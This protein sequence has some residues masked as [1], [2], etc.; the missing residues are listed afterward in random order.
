V[1]SGGDRRNGHGRRFGGC[2]QLNLSEH[3]IVLK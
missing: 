1:I 3:K 2:W